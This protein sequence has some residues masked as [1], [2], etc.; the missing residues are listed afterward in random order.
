MKLKNYP[1]KKCSTYPYQEKEY[2]CGRFNCGT[3]LYAD[4]ALINFN[5]E[6]YLPFK[7]PNDPRLAFLFSSHP[8]TCNISENN[9]LYITEY[10][11]CLDQKFTLYHSFLNPPPFSPN[12]TTPFGPHW[13]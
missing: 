4:A 8:F 10:N 7:I 2:I 3:T 11:K 5:L 13:K 12:N 1:H 9:Q 6:M